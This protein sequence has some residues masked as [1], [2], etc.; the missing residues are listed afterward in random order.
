MVND[1]LP[2]DFWTLEEQELLAV[3]L[4]LL[5]EMA[6]DG[7]AISLDELAGYSVT[8]DPADASARTSAWAR[9]YAG[10]LIRKI[11]PTTRAS[12]GEAVANWFET[13]GATMG[14]LSRNL[15]RILGSNEYR[16]ALIATTETTRAYAEG[17]D[18]AR[19]EAG[20]PATVFKGPAH[21]GCRCFDSSWML[22]T[23]EWVVLWQTNQDE[24]VCTQP[25][26]TPWGTVAGCRELQG[27]VISEGPYLGMTLDEAEARAAQ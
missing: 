5:E 16:A 20:L 11:N 9:A 23:G 22:S 7:I 6:R 21:P 3:L 19:R 4:P 18:L 13:P 17:S 24:I 8:A 10:E 1:P 27:R 14:D 2:P 15:Q 25:I 26:Q 12:V